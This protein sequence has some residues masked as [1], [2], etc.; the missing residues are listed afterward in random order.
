MKQLIFIALMLVF[1][2]AASAQEAEDTGWKG[3]Y[4]GSVP[5][6]NDLIHTKAD[7]KFDY[8]KAYLYGKVWLTLK[9]HFYATDSLKL[10]AKGMDIKSVS[11]AKGSST[12]PLKYKYDGLELN[13]DLGKLY[14][15]NEK[16][17]VYI[18]YRH[19]H[20]CSFSFTLRPYLCWL[21]FIFSF[22]IYEV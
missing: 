20:R 22:R 13:I 11:L 1:N 15:R 21:V 17:T 16:Y 19:P 7:V 4:R 12:I 10:D 2:F 14:T 8:D 5:Q 3:V 9:P 6:V 18:D